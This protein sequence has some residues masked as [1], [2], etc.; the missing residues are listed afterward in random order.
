MV[1][2]FLLCA[3]LSTPLAGPRVIEDDYGK[4]LKAAKASGKLLFVD[5]WAPWCHTCVFMREHVLTRPAFATFEKDVVFAAIDTEKARNAAFL[6]K[7]PVDVWPTLYFIDPSSEALVFKWIGSADEAQM[8][9]LLSAAKGKGT[10]VAEA[11]ALLA[12]GDAT[13]AAEKYLAAVK[14]GGGDSRTTLSALSALYLAKQHEACAR[15]ADEQLNALTSPGDRVNG[16]VWGLGCALDLPASPER[17]KLLA[18]FVAEGKKALTLEGVLADDVSGLYDALVSERQDAKDGV[19]AEA[20]A[21]DWLT[22]LEGQAAKATT[23]A[24]RAV[25]D[26][27]RVSAALAGKHPERALDALARSEA[28]LPKDYNPPARLAILYRELGQYDAALAAADRALKKCAEGP[29]KLRVYE[30]KAT[31]LSKKGD[32]AAQKQTLT[33]AVAYAKK[34]PKAQRSEQRIAALEKQAQAIPP[35]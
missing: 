9:A 28:E 31:I 25:F 23:P 30:T 2:A 32:R 34:L 12:K 13:T 18:R 22:F 6:E 4:A 20:L 7:F 15:T 26:P 24:A 33:E 14:A 10:P 11:D 5:A 21:L 16:I 27:H 19:A 17:T 8:T 3:V 35:P 1:T 29:R